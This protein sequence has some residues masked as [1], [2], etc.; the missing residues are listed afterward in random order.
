MVR[1]TWN[2]HETLM[3]VLFF[4]SIFIIHN[5][6]MNCN[7]GWAPA[8]RLNLV[9]WSTS[10][11]FSEIH[12]NLYMIIRPIESRSVINFCNFQRNP[13]GYIHESRSVINFC[14][15]QQNPYGYMHDYRE[16]FLWDSFAVW[17]IFRLCLHDCK[18]NE[19]LS[20]KYLSIVNKGVSVKSFSSLISCPC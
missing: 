18:M 2:K 3:N 4:S 19:P 20:L 9:L 1:F 12:M 16:D 10:V 13:Y 7:L 6:W 8:G 11:I 17:T 15:F 14:N 5:H